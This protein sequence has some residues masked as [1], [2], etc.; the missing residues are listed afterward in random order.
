MEIRLDRPDPIELPDPEAANFFS[1][2]YFGSDFQL[3]VGYLDPYLVHVR[4][5]EA[6]ERE[7]DPALPLLVTHRFLL[8]VNAVHLL[9][10]QVDEIL[11]K[12]EAAQAAQEE[13]PE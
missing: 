11:Q 10:A 4:Q 1:F 2:S 8:S 7:E 5:A 13:S 3:E 12:L 9:K 6:R